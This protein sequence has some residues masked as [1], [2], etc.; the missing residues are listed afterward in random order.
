ML[1]T[2]Q[3]LVDDYEIIPKETVSDFKY[4]YLTVKKKSIREYIQPSR[5]V[6]R[7]DLRFDKIICSPSEVRDFARQT[8]DAFGFIDIRAEEQLHN[9]AYML[10]NRFKVNRLNC[11]MELVYSDKCRRFH[12]DNVYLRSITT[13]I[14]PGTELQMLDQNEKVFRVNTGDTVLVKGKQFPGEATKVLHRSP[15]ISHLGIPRVVFVMDY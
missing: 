5:Q 1:G 8:L 14:G 15:R 3:D 9:V 11:R 4:R 12:V 7:D 13:L 6:H 10:M 2:V